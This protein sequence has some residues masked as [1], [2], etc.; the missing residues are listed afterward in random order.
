MG[1]LRKDL[2]GDL[3]PAVSLDGK[4]E[5]MLDLTGMEFIADGLAD[6]KTFDGGF[7]NTLITFPNGDQYIVGSIDLE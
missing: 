5:S 6:D 7:Y 1:R 2:E 3:I 4:I